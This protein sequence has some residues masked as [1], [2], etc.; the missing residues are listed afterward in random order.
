MIC[1]IFRQQNP[2]FQEELEKES[3]KKRHVILK[4]G[5]GDGQGRR[6][7]TDFSYYACQKRTVCFCNRGRTD[8]VRVMRKYI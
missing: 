1:M 8:F 2:E 4:A 7:Q 5:M 3:S 6:A